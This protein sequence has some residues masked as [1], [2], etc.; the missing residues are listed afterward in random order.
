MHT[1]VVTGGQIVVTQSTDYY[2]FGLEHCSGISGDNRYL[3]NGKEMQEEF[4]I[5]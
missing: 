5:I 3:Y 4:L 1:G 2:P